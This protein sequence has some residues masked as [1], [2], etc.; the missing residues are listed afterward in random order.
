MWP[1]QSV[2]RQQA[3]GLLANIT[4]VADADLMILKILRLLETREV[5]RSVDGQT[6]KNSLLDLLRAD[7]GGDE[8]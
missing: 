6:G 3:E 5:P 1:G 7:P 4:E 8:Q 2:Y